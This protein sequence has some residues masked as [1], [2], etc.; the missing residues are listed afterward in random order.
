M[1]YH[2]G[3]FSNEGDEFPSYDVGL[4]GFTG[5]QGLLDGLEIGEGNMVKVVWMDF[6]PANGFQFV[7]TQ[8]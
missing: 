6:Y 4:G 7:F 2:G 1:V 3:V 8:V 5:L